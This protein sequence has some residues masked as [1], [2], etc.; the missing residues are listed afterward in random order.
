MEIILPN[1]IHRLIYTSNIS[2]SVVSAPILQFRSIL[3]RSVK[4]NAAHDITGCLIFDGLRFVQIIEGKRDVI[5]DLFHKLHLDVRHFDIELVEFV[6][7]DER[8]FEE[9]AM[10]GSMRISLQEQIYAKH[11]FSERIKASE[12]TAAK[13]IPLALEL[14]R[15]L[16]NE[17]T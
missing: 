11:G 5:S 6:A 2:A 13:I 1:R 3:E 7:V 10:A 8:M 4:Y 9:W 12:L 17:P 14:L 16:K 15:T